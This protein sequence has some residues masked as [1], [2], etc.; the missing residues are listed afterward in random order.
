MK[1]QNQTEGKIVFR[2]YLKVK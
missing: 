2:E 1:N